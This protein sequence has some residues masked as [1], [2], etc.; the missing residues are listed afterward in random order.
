[1]N[2]KF[3]FPTT[4]AWPKEVIATATTH[5]TAPLRAWF[6]ATD[7]ELRVRLGLLNP[8]QVPQAKAD[9]ER[10]RQA[11]CERLH[12]EKTLT[13]SATDDFQ[14]FRAAVQQYLARSPS[15]LLEIRLCNLGAG[16]TEPVNM[17]GL[18]VEQFPSWQVKMS[19]SIEDLM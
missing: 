19:T 13:P 9:R 15:D 14:T 18:G 4:R 8:E 1:D 2:G 10:E 6:E 16:E 17:P 12:A 5:D 7:V 11:L 3:A